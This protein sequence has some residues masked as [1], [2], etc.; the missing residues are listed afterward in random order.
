MTPRHPPHIQA[1]LTP[2]S[3]WPVIFSGITLVSTFVLMVGL[4]LAGV[5]LIG[6]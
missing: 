6:W 3:P 5:G 2:Y 4:A 1:L